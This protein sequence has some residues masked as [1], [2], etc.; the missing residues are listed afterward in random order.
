[1]IGIELKATLTPE[2]IRRAERR[3]RD[4]PSVAAAR[5]TFH[6]VETGRAQIDASV[7]ERDR[8]PHGLGGLIR[9]GFGALTDREIALAFNSVTGGGEAAGASWRWWE[10][11]PMAAGFYAA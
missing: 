11:R 3:T 10:H 9:I 6:P 8:A 4:V 7:V 1:A 5:V 2:A